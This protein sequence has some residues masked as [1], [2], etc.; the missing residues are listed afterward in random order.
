MTA[1][2]R[3]YNRQDSKRHRSKSKAFLEALEGGHF[4]DALGTL[5]PGSNPSSN[6]HYRHRQNGDD[7]YS[8]DESPYDER[9]HHRH[10]R[11]DDYPSDEE[12]LYEE[13]KPSRRH[14][15]THT[16]R[17]DYDRKGRQQHLKRASSGP[18]LK[19]AAG[20]AVAAGLVEAWRARYDRDRTVRVATAAI[21]AAATDAFIAKD[22]D[23]KTKRHVVESVIAGLAENRVLNG[24]R[25]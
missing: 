12:Y 19:Q 6:D 21:G 13:T 2:G 15:S 16:H 9:S 22:G 17:R 4:R 8:Y 3:D 5:K 10:S 18:D 20:A 23:R 25:R 11:Y 14:R 24:A 1:R 7:Y